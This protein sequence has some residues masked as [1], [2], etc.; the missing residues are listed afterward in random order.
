M[1]ENTQ[2]Q[3]TGKSIFVIHLSFLKDLT[4]KYLTGQYQLTRTPLYL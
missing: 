1:R 3:Q 4:G 2:N